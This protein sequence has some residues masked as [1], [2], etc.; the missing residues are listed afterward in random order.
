MAFRTGS[1]TFRT[2]SAVEFGT[3]TVLTTGTLAFLGFYISF[4][5]L[6]NDVGPILVRK[7]SISLN[8]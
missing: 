2:G 6:G 3:I 4:G 8:R 5:L 7:L 1:T